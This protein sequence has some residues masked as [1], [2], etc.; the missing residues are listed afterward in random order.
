[1]L[2]GGFAPYTLHAHFIDFEEADNESKDVEVANIGFTNLKFKQFVMFIIY[3]FL[4]IFHE[5]SNRSNHLFVN[6][7]A[8]FIV[9]NAQ[10]VFYCTLQ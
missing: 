7:T 6:S 2:Q 4:L 8:H 3:L 1:M 9:P 5:R 10:L